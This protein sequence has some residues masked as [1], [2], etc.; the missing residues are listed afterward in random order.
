MLKANHDADVLFELAR[1]ASRFA[2]LSTNGANVS[3]LDAAQSEVFEGFQSQ[4]VTCLTAAVNAGF[5][6]AH[7]F[8]SE[9]L[10]IFRPV[11][12]Y[13]K[14]GQTVEEQLKFQK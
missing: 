11:T 8:L 5:S 3:E 7:Q 10:D 1:A 2:C 13:I 4:S 6:K 9:D 14:A 12:G